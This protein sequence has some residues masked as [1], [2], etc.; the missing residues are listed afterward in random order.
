[1]G[2]GCGGGVDDRQRAL[3]RLV[4]IARHFRDHERRMIGTNPAFPNLYRGDLYHAFSSV[5]KGR[6][7]GGSWSALERLDRG[8]VRSA[9][10]RLDAYHM[11][12]VGS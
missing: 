12:S 11:T 7:S 1:M 8:F 10:I 3:E 9:D 6:R 2:A 5:C 4:V